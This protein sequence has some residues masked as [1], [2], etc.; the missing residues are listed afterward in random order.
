MYFDTRYSFP[1]LVNL[2]KFAFLEKSYSFFIFFIL[3]AFDF[4][5][6]FNKWWENCMPYFLCSIARHCI[7]NVIGCFCRE[8][9]PRSKVW[10][11]LE[12][13]EIAAYEFAEVISFTKCTRQVS[14][15]YQILLH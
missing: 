15:P 3:L 11:E 12:Q 13:L 7:F 10:T 6:F 14:Q 8:I 9:G 4:C 1:C 2:L 5:R